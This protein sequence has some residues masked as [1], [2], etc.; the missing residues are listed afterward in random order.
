MGT[1]K[2]TALYNGL[3]IQRIIRM[4][5]Q[6]DKKNYNN[7]IRTRIHIRILF[8]F[9]TIRITFHVSVIFGMNGMKEIHLVSIQNNEFMRVNLSKKYIFLS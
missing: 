2:A 3:E 1:F 7:Q 5:Q 4:N 6:R 8:I 9:C